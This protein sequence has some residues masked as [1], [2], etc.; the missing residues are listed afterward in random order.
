MIKENKE[1][2]LFV[3]ITPVAILLIIWIGIALSSCLY[4]DPVPSLLDILM[5]IIRFVL[6][7]RLW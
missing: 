1:D 6:Q 5:M 3:V 7:L 2:I 4:G